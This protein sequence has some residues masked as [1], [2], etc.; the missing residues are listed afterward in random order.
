M[1]GHSKWANI[2]HKKAKEDAKRGQIF[3]KLGRKITVAAKEGGPDPTSNVRLRLAIEEA[4][5]EE[6]AELEKELA[7]D[8]LGM[9]PEDAPGGARIAFGPFLALT[10][11]EIALFYQPLLN[12]VREQLLL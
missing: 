12:L 10:I 2:K 8:P 5:G 11:L 7:D 9:D 6:R 4:E 1:A 3:T